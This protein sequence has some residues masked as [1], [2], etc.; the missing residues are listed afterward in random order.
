MTPKWSIELKR[1]ALKDLKK[2][3][4]KAQEKIFQYLENKVVSSGNVRSFG[5]PLTGVLSGLWRYRVGDYRILCEIQDKK[6]IIV[7]VQVAHR[8]NVYQKAASH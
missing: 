5:K 8:K 4:K 1:G 3:D 2:I 7:I 6:L